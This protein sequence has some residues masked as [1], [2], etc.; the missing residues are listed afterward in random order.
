[1]IHVRIYFPVFPYNPG[2]G[3]FIPDF[4]FGEAGVMAPATIVLM[5]TFGRSLRRSFA[6]GDVQKNVDDEG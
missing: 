2:S 4:F 6:I 3:R 1:L 5:G